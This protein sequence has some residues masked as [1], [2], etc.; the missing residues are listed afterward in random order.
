M[1]SLVLLLVM[2]NILAIRA[3]ER[4]MQREQ[5]IGLWQELFYK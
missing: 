2:F 1:K 3:H 4:D 5:L